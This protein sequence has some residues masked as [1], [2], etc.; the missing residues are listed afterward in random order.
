MAIQAYWELSVINGQ[1]VEMEVGDTAAGPF[2]VQR[3]RVV[4]WPSCAPLAG[5]ILKTPNIVVV[6]RAAAM[7]H[8]FS[9]ATLPAVR[10]QC[11]A[12]T[13]VAAAW[14]AG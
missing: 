10:A 13:A 5:S 7:A 3:T 8:R 11:V 6:C 9:R 12:G 1:S 2:A 14:T 4:W